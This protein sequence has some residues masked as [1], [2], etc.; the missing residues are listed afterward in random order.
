MENPENKTLVSKIIELFQVIFRKCSKLFD[1]IVFNKKGS[2][3]ISFILAV[4]ISISV[5]YEDISLTL[6]HDTTVSV[7]END[8]SVEVLADTD[9]YVV[10]GIPNS[11][12]VTITGN[13]PDV[14]VF[15]QQGNIKVVADVRKYTA[16]QV[17]V[18]ME[19]SQLPPNLKATISPATVEAKIS[20]K[21][22]KQFTVAPELLL[23]SGQKES[24]FQ[25]PVLSETTVQIKAS[26]EQIDSIRTVKAIIDA[27]GQTNDFTISA[28]IVAYDSNGDPIQ[29]DIEPS[30]VQASVAFADEAND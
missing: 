18:D 19:V 15:R 4:F 1:K 11:V 27:T 5:N 8:V 6:F 2:I 14:Q 7:T 24:D 13:A 30:T 22:T 20:K 21:I 9:N 17:M 3:L 28:S 25:T 26:Q 29:V 16:G 23:G 12:D 10:E